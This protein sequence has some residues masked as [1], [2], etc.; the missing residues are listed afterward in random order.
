MAAEATVGGEMSMSTPTGKTWKIGGIILLAIAL[1]AFGWQQAIWPLNQGSER[2]LERRVQQFWDLKTSGDTLGAY[3]YMVKVW[4][5]DREECLHTLS[6]H[7]NRVYSLQ[8]ST[9]H[10]TAA[11]NTYQVPT[12]F[13]I[14]SQL[15]IMF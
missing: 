10:S 5:P 9:Q 14:S 1:L 15:T 7:T 11:V 2:A 6:G 13:L 8:V 4:N 12:T 3:D